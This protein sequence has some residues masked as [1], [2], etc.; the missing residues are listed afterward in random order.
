MISTSDINTCLGLS[1]SLHGYARV[2]GRNGGQFRARVSPP[3]VRSRP[4]RRSGGLRA[5]SR[6]ACH[7]PGPAASGG[8]ARRERCRDERVSPGIEGWRA[9][10][11][12]SNGSSLC[13]RKATINAS[14]SRPRV[15][16]CG[17]A[18]PLFRSATEV[19]LRHFRTVTGL[20]PYRGAS[21]C[22]FFTPLGRSTGRPVSPSGL[23]ERSRRG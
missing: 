16:A 10:R 4:E 3:P 1:L 22:A 15:V 2:S 17:S 12:S 19:R 14:C 18:G 20:I 5:S 8:R 21:A 11:P 9:E 7:P 13:R 23:P 6:P